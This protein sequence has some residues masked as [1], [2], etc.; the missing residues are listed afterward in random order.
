MKK[1]LLNRLRNDKKNY[2]LVIR[3]GG[4]ECKGL[5]FFLMKR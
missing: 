5:R 1:C 3:D 4:R 2:L